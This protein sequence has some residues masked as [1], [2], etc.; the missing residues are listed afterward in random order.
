[1]LLYV[2]VV[3]KKIFKVPRPNL[4]SI[5]KLRNILMA[6]RIHLQIIEYDYE[7]ELLLRNNQ[8]EIFHPSEYSMS[9]S[10]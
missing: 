10:Q 6:L 4:E 1:M 2:K 7:P 8:T 9:V 5:K 3:P